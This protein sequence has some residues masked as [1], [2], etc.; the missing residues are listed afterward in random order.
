MVK[1]DYL[2]E[3]PVLNP[4]VE[5]CIEFIPQKKYRWNFQ[6]VW[7]SIYRKQSTYKDFGRLCWRL[8][9]RWNGSDPRRR[10]GKGRPSHRKY[11]DD[12]TDCSL[13]IVVEFAGWDVWRQIL[14]RYIDADK[15]ALL[16]SG[17][18]Q[19]CS[20]RRRQC[21]TS[22]QDH[23]R[24]QDAEHRRE[25]RRKWRDHFWGRKSQDAYKRP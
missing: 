25:P 16:V 8:P 13:S 3:F 14:V 24:S 20:N 22:H 5:I 19:S 11:G 7:T 17:R 1:F 15:P 23:S 18:R 9:W 4:A 10:L 2:L 21:P 12:R 6:L